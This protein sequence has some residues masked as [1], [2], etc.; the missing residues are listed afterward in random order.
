MRTN[1]IDWRIATMQFQIYD[2]PATVYGTQGF[3]EFTSRPS[4]QFEYDAP[5]EGKIRD[6]ER[7]IG[8]ARRK[9]EPVEELVE[10]KRR[11][12]DSWIARLDRERGNAADKRDQERIR[13][14]LERAQRE[15]GKQ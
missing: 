12:Y 5:E 4:M 7:Q 2:A 13:Q 10:E 14:Q 3:R 15:Y 9:G 6:L 11:T 8:E 1:E